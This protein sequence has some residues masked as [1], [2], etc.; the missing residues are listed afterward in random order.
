MKISIR[1]FLDSAIQIRVNILIV[2]AASQAHA[3]G[4]E[5]KDMRV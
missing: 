2:T 1:G 4:D 3:A 5:K